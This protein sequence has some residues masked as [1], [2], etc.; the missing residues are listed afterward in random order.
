VTTGVRRLRGELLAGLAAD[1]GSVLDLDEPGALERVIEAGRPDPR[2]AGD[3]PGYDHVVST[4]RLVDAPDL[5]RALT[6]MVRWLGP[7]GELHL[8]EP[9]GRPGNLGLLASSVGA[10]L[11]ATAG[12]HLSR[13]VPAAV[14]ATGLTVVDLDRVT[15]PTLVWPLR[16]LV[17][18]RA[19]RLESVAVAEPTGRE[20]PA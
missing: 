12:L 5:L 20:V 15:V 4:G 2:P 7:A 6:G 10:H 16:H 9:V 1:G 17:V 3:R 19:T 14:R 11:G 13:D 8:V 18:L